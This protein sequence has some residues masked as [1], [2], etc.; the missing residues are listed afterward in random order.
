[1]LVLA[2]LGLQVQVVVGMVLQVQV[3]VGM[4]LQVQVVIVL[5]Y[6]NSYH[7]QDYFFGFLDFE[8][9]IW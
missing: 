4:V 1:M 2:I 6:E 8:Q 7:L 5:V 9:G 3:V